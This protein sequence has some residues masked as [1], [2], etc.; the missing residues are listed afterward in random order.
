MD[1]SFLVD[2]K[3]PRLLR[4][5]APKHPVPTSRGGR[6]IRVRVLRVTVALRLWRA[7]EHLGD[8]AL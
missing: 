1:Q 5:A 7:L 8:L 6:V 3:E 4:V 2:V